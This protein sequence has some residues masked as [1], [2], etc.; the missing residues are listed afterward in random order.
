ME[1]PGVSPIIAS[2]VLAKVPDSK[3]FRSGRSFASCIGL[4]GRDHGTGGKHR[5]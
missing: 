4:T 5:P 2:T 1:V 3:V